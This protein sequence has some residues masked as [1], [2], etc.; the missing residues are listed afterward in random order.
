MALHIM[1]AP[2]RS[3]QL[4]H[5][6]PFLGQ[7]HLRLGVVSD[8]FNLRKQRQVDLC[9]FKDSLFSSEF[10][11][12][13]GY[14]V[15]PYLKKLSNNKTQ[16]SLHNSVEISSVHFCKVLLSHIKLNSLQICTTL[17]GYFVFHFI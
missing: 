3:E 12:S 9:E 6:I 5:Y 13:Q 1:Q 8:T 4:K 16:L 10:Q 2:S 15:R 11:A 17:D 14:T 7:S